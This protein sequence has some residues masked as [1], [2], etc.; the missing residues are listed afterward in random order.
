MRHLVKVGEIHTE[1][2]LETW[3]KRPLKIPRCIWEDNITMDLKETGCKNVVWI[4]PTHYRV[5]WG[6]L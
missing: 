1:Y 3:R 5:Q 6:I 2:Q 4:Q